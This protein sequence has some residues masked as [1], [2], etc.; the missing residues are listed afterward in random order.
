VAGFLVVVIFQGGFTFY[1]ASAGI[2]GGMPQPSLPLLYIMTACT[3][4]IAGA[5]PL[6]QV[7]QHKEDA[8]NGDITISC[9]LGYKGTFL[10]TATMF[11]LSMLF[12]GLY[13]SSKGQLPYFYLLQLFFLPALVYFLTWFRAV[14]RNTDAANFRNTMKM[15]L[16]ASS[17]TSACFILFIILKYAL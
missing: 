16:I 5:Y 17:C 7:Y 13:F 6:T 3:L 1:M 4:Q 15:N 2:T 10:F 9:R 8:A 11:L 14:A 12:Y